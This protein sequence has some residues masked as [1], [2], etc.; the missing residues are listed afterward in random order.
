MFLTIFNLGYFSFVNSI[1][2]YVLSSFNKILYFGSY[3]L[4]KVISRIS[5]SNSL[6]VTIYSKSSISYTSILVFPVTVPVK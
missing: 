3:F 1:Y 5:D 2:G 6:D 4:I